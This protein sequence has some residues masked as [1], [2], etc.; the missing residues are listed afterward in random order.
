MLL[1]ALQTLL[2]QF[3]SHLINRMVWL[4]KQ[5]HFAGNLWSYVKVKSSDDLPSGN[6]GFV[7]PLTYFSFG[8]E[9]PNCQ[10]KSQNQYDWTSLAQMF[11]SS[12]QTNLDC[13]P[14]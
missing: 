11:V 9:Y 13:S 7:I 14:L 2:R 10:M 12:V 4:L 6:P 1:I 3:K 5:L 8:T